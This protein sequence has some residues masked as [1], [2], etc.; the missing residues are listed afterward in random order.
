MLTTLNLTFLGSDAND[1]VLLGTDGLQTPAGE[2]GGGFPS[3]LKL[4]L[5]DRIIGGSVLPVSGE[6]LPPEASALLEDGT[7]PAGTP[8]ASIEV[9][10]MPVEWPAGLVPS[11]PV[12]ADMPAVTG[13]ATSIDDAELQ[14]AAQ[15]GALLPPRV[16]GEPERTPASSAAARE[17]LAVAETAPKELP[18][19][20]RYAD[21]PLARTVP[22][23]APVPAT[24]GDAPVVD[25]ALPASIAR[26]TVVAEAAG[27]RALPTADPVADA[28]LRG[29]ALP[30]VIDSLRKDSAAPRTASAVI[31]DAGATVG[32]ATANTAP[33]RGPTQSLPTIAAPV[34]DTAWA[35]SLSDR[36]LMMTSNKIGNAEIRLTPAELG[37]LR[38]QVAVDDSTATVAFQ[39]TNAATRDAIEQALPRLR[40]MLADSGLSLGQASVGDH[41]VAREGADQGADTDA[42][43]AADGDDGGAL[44]ET[45]VAGST[46]RRLHDGLVDTFA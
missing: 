20:P 7:P 9:S 39:A 2:D 33:S 27:E 15:S 14:T 5:E 38:I 17:P 13:T 29:A 8:A 12:E 18:I 6:G 25:Y 43:Y 24:G 34:A 10:E 42:P 28:T 37:P 11:T 19:I 21:R 16:A 40:E 3:M 4:S 22:Q 26:P 30:E 32:Q 1:G 46:P 36:V 35:E 41:G 44:S 31:P 45:T 23:P